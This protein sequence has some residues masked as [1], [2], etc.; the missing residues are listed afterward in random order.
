VR[1]RK[2]LPENVRQLRGNPGKSK[3]INEP[4]PAPKMPTCP[5]WLPSEAKNEWKR[6]TVELDRIGMLTLVDR[7]A[8]ASYCEAWAMLKKAEE[9]I[10]RHGIVHYRVLREVT[11]E[12]GNV[13]QLVAAVERN[14]ATMIA[15]QALSHIRA[16]ASEFGLTPSSRSRINVPKPTEDDLREL[17]SGPPAF[18]AS[19]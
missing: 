19:P 8:L 13:V 12:D 3:P 1:G 6:V 5:S 17:L 14:P 2:P 9:E 16:F 10:H 18:E 11:D 4:K 7:G 15:H